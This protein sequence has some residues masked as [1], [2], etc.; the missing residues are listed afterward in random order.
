MISSSLKASVKHAIDG[1]VLVNTDREHKET[2]TTPFVVIGSLIAIVLLI[3]MYIAVGK[4]G[5]HLLYQQST[6]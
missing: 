5:K 3:V 2:T 1:K 6:S 4:K